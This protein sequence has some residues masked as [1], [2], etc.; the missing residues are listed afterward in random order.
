M[1]RSFHDLASLAARLGVG[2]H[3]LSDGWQKLEAGL[4]ATGDRFAALGAPG[5]GV[6][7][8]V[9][10]L[11][12]LVGGALLVAGLAV[13]VCGLLLFGEVAAVFALSAG[14]RSLPPTADEVSL[15]VA[16]GAACV[17]LAAGGA[18]RLSIDRM[19]MIGRRRAASGD[20]APEGETDDVI[21]A[22]R[23]A[24]ASEPVPTGTGPAARAAAP[25]APVTV[26]TAATG[27]GK[28]AA[29][30]APVRPRPRGSRAAPPAPGPGKSGDTLV[31]GGKGDTPKP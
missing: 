29:K 25:D 28:E 31:A 26:P 5:P 3:F 4:T 14:A 22:L 11:I 24:E 17:L 27:P 30:P 18:G 12:E 8:A 9:T 20:F 2:G 1:R 10:M 23:D 13:P 6:W 21:T 15:V 7:A 19:V 16:L